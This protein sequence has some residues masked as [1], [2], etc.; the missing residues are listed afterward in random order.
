MNLLYTLLIGLLVGAV[1]RF[2]T[3]GKGPAGLVIT[4]LL[5]IAGALVGTWLGQ[6]LGVYEPGARAGFL[7]SILGAMLVLY[8]YRSIK[9][10]S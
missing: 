5:G 2:F 10:R 4:M 7:G 3:P 6:Q 8:A 1:A 9:G